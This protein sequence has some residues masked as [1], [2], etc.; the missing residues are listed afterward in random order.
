MECGGGGQEGARRVE[1]VI[2]VTPRDE[3]RGPDI[4]QPGGSAG[5]KGFGRQGVL[6]RRALGVCDFPVLDDHVGCFELSVV[7]LHCFEREGCLLLGV[8]EQLDED[9]LPFPCVE[10][11]LGAMDVDSHWFGL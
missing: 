3:K 10:L 2:K 9:G 4:D 11:G 8:K 1:V 7:P 6:N 5:A